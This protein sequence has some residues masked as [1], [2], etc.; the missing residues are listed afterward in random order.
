MR[1]TPKAANQA[2][3]QPKR[4]KQGLT[5]RALLATPLALAATT[6]Q[7]RT[8][9]P[10]TPP[11]LSLVVGS[12]PG[13]GADPSARAFAPFLERHLRNVRVAVLNRPGEAGLAAL[14]LLAS[15]DASGLTLGWVSSPTLPARMV[16]RD[17]PGLLDR[18]RLVGA[19]QKEPLVFVSS[20]RS[21]LASV[22]DLLRRA[23]KDSAAMALGTPPEGSPG[24]LVALRLQALTGTKLQIVAFPSATAARQAAQEGHAA[25]A[26]LAMADAI[27]AL[28][29]GTLSGLGVATRRPHRAMPDVAPLHAS[30]VALQATILRGLALPAAAD[31]ARI[32][33]LQSALTRIA[34]DPEFIAA[35]DESGFQPIT[36]PGPAW[37]AEV[38]KDY[39]IFTTLWSLSP[40]TPT[41]TG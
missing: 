28:R 12:P 41:P 4:T 40:W 21:P 20:P 15:S 17:A 8:Q 19:V 25:A 22:G 23:G 27:E 26:V 32:A 35:G 29:D 38:E 14:R 34:A 37:T 16:D 13:R 5:R 9:P 3:N 11:L 1:G 10:P 31:P 36:L 30:G 2:E 24:H 7:A 33:A 6:A 39:A 18:L